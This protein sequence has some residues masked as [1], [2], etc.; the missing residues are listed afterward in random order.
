MAD[1]LK[2]RVI[3]QGTKFYRNRTIVIPMVIAKLHGIEEG[4]EIELRNTEEGLLIL[5]PDRREASKN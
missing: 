1:I 4:M 3:G 2:R 5:Y